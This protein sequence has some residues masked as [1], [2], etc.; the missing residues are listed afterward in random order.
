M[1]SLLFTQCLQNDFIKPVGVYAPLPNQLHI[2]HK[3]A[4]RLSGLDPAESPL[5]RMMEWA[6]QRSPDE[7]MIVHIRDWHD[8]DDPRQTEHLRQFT[9]HCMAGTEGADF[10]FAVPSHPKNEPVEI[11][12][13]TLN[14]FRD[15]DLDH[16]LAPFADQDVT[17]GIVGVWTEAKVT[18]LAYELATRFPT[19]KLGVCPALTAS[20]SR[21]RHFF[22]LDQLRRILRVHVPASVGDFIEFLGGE[23]RNYPLTG[24]HE[25]HPEVMYDRS[26]LPEED[27]VLLRYLFRNCREVRTSVLD[28]GFSGNAVLGTRSIDMHGHEQVPHVIKIGPRSLIGQE[29]TSFER[30]EEVLGNHAPRITDFADFGDRGAIKYRYASMYGA[31]STTFQKS[32]VAGMPTAKTR[33]VLREV[34]IDQ[35]GKLYRAAELEPIDLLTYYQFDPKWAKSVRARVEALLGEKVDGDEIRIGSLPPVPNPCLFYE[36]DLAHLDAMRRDSSYLAYVHGD[37]NGANIILDGHENVWIIDFF[38]THRGHILRDL[39]KLENDVLYIYTPVAREDELAQAAKLT[40]ALV[41]VADLA[42]PLPGADAVGITSPAMRRA[43][44]TVCILRGFYGDL[45]KSDRAPLQW[46]IPALRY[47]VHTLSFD[48]S[49]EWQR[50]WALYAASRYADRIR[51]VVH[52]QGPLRVDCIDERHTAPGRLGITILPGRLDHQRD[53]AADLARLKELRVTDVVCL[54]PLPELSQYGVP[55]LLKRYAAAGFGVRH[56]PIIDQKVCA[57]DEMH[58]TV[59]WIRE[60]TDRGGFVAVHCV[61]GL[62]RSGIA[63]ASYL[64]ASGLDA[65]DAIAEVRR[66]RSPRAVENRTQE[67]FV[68]RFARGEEHAG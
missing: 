56:V 35:L 62:G 65:P 59:K 19:W 36:R 30:I 66:A 68:E 49:D 50:K 4:L 43:Y 38:H 54:V 44:E 18:F 45:I 63:A 14:D 2:G 17:A 28:G 20:S 10:A 41:A 46:L 60:R 37:L 42:A 9:A 55:D 23:A 22:A 24:L 64:V 25:A 27:E 16:V 26:S 61:G 15:T 29:R 32:Y 40:D 34:F 1:P 7:L 21:E 51:T 39:V 5:S 13:L 31:T 6:Y 48:E 47:A 8:A 58:E 3:E 52:S 33:A 57:L 53:L 67:A 11:R 12:S